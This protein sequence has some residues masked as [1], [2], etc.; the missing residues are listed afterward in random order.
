MKVYISTDIEGAA[1]VASWE[2]TELN[3]PEH[4]A[5]ALEMTKEAVAACRGAIAAGAEEIYVKD[6]HDSGRNM[7]LSLFPPQARLIS[8]WSLTPD[9]MIAGLD[10]SFDAVMFVGYHSPAGLA[11]SPLSHTMN[12]DNIRVTVNGQLA[13]EFS[14]HALLAASRGVPSVFLSG[15]KAVCGHAQELV[16]AITAVPVKEGLGRAT[17]SLPPALALEQIEEGARLS[18]SRR[19]QCLPAVPKKLTMEIQFRDH[20]RALRASYYPGV[21]QMDSFT[22]SYTAGTVDELMAARM[23]IL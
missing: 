9:S 22:V 4:K 19:C 17:I 3:N 12:R 6:A 23:F 2:A 8:D 5:A 20:Y 7:N 15:D 1:G 21:T 11:G 14:L 16:P 10:R 18:L 13:S